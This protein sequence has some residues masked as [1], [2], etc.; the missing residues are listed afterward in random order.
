M[1]NDLER[2]TRQLTVLSGK[3]AEIQVRYGEVVN[4][5]K[6]LQT[7]V[8]QHHP[9]IMASK[10]GDRFAQI[11]RC[12]ND[13]NASI[14]DLSGHMRQLKIP[15]S[16]AAHSIQNVL[17]TAGKHNLDQ[18]M[19][20]MDDDADSR[21]DGGKSMFSPE[22]TRQS[23]ADDSPPA[24]PAPRTQGTADHPDT[25]KDDGTAPPPRSNR[26]RQTQE[27]TSEWLQS[28]VTA[29]DISSFA[30]KT[31]RESTMRVSSEHQQLQ[32]DKTAAMMSERFGVPLGTRA[33]MTQKPGAQANGELRVGFDEGGELTMIG[34]G[35]E[36]GDDFEGSG[37]FGTS[38]R[39]APGAGAK[40]GSMPFRS[41]IATGASSRSSV[42]QPKSNVLPVRLRR[43]TVNQSTWNGELQEAAR[44][45][46]ST[47]EEKL[48]QIFQ[49]FCSFG[50]RGNVEKMSNQKF[51]KFCKDFKLID[52]SFAI[53]EVDI[54]F[55]RAV[56]QAADK[57]EGGSPN[58]QRAV[59]AF[60]ARMNFDQFVEALADIAH[61]KNPLVHDQDALRSLILDQIMPQYPE[62]T[63]K[64]TF[65]IDIRRDGADER[66]QMFAKDFYDAEVKQFFRTND[67]A[68][69]NLFMR[70]AGLNAGAGME[71]PPHQ[72]THNTAAD[73]T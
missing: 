54:V 15:G 20:S 68:L 51:N 18:T 26:I 42:S 25:F 35:A 40:K 23:G 19:E 9:V 1:K 8:R 59:A 47:I 13:I 61:R 17:H 70:Y 49:Y 73:C 72:H 69:R 66:L 27:P 5:N 52:Q 4:L 62:L 7:A 48:Q 10:H 53:S 38:P 30:K 31:R 60:G 16:T 21:L 39:H 41:P 33:V 32:A 45:T 11:Q 71:R 43:M 24:P 65:M 3:M 56:L 64:T 2:T 44:P 63:K 22:Q 36:A 67:K 28:G 6:S 50:D 29:A 46:R 58:K 12:T 57:S 55:K 37:I 34:E 14:V